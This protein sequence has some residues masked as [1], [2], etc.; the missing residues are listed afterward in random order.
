MRLFTLFCSRR[1]IRQVAIYVRQQVSKSSNYAES[2]RRVAG[3]KPGRPQALC[4]DAAKPMT[5]AHVSNREPLT[6]YICQ[7]FQNSR[8]NRASIFLRELIVIS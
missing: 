6:R 2:M 7:N 3:G 1:T 4:L 8:M 5:L